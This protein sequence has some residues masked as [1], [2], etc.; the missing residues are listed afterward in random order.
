V[1][2]ANC[3]TIILALALGPLYQSFDLNRAHVVTMQAVSGAGYPGVASLDIVGNVIP[4]IRNEEEKVESETLKILGRLAGS[5]FQPATLIVSAQTNRVPV[6][7]GHLECVSV[8]LGR[9]A[10][11]EELV[12]CWNSFRGRPQELELPSA[13]KAPIVFL[14]EPDRPQPRFD[15]EKFG[16]MSVLVGRLRPC[17][18]LDYKFIVLGHNTVRGA[19]GASILNAEL[20]V[21]LGML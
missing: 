11:P 8:G 10:S 3:S 19:A 14:P 12:N 21:K 2:N 15:V 5:E 7:D 16:G 1:T 4:F 18:L 13:P 17:S 6:E 9:K 20:A